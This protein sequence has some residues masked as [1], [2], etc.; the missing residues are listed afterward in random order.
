M[1]CSNNVNF[2]IWKN[3]LKIL[4]HILITAKNMTSRCVGMSQTPISSEINIEFLKQLLKEAG[5]TQTLLF[6][7]MIDYTPWLTEYSTGIQT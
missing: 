5:F 1:C 3:G 6:L 2:W 4:K 7:P